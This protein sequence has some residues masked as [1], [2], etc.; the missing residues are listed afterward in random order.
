MPRPRRVVLALADAHSPPCRH[1]PVSQK[2][3][4]T[5]RQ[6]VTLQEKLKRLEKEKHD[7][8]AKF[9]EVRRRRTLTFRRSP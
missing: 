4:Q 9:R 7:A 1:H 2:L 6:E 3:A 8:F 5:K